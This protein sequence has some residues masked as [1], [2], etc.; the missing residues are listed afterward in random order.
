MIRG[1]AVRSS[2]NDLWNLSYPPY[3]L[4]IY[5]AFPEQHKKPAV[6]C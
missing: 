4:K 2:F 3:L 5:Q 1:Y 6:S